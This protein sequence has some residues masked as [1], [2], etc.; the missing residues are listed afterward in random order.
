MKVVVSIYFSLSLWQRLILK[1]RIFDV[2]LQHSANRVFGRDV[3]PEKD[4]IPLFQDC[5]ERNEHFL[6]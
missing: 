3:E 6:C 5:Q 2:L 1:R 4:A